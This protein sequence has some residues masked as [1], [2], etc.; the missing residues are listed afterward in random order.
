MARE[1]KVKR[2]CEE[3]PNRVFKPEKPCSKYTT[4]NIEQFE[5]MRLCDLEGLDQ[6]EAAKRMN[7]SRGTLQ[8]VL[9]AARK[10]VAEALVSG[11]GIT[12]DGGNYEIARECCKAKKQCKACRFLN[13]TKG[14]DKN[15]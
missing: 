1:I 3:P 15:E 14:D 8:R 4:L 11:N 5:A 2:V 9:Y 6:D 13:N 12:I 10:Q 7:I